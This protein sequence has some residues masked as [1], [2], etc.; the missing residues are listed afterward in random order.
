MTTLSTA[1]IPLERNLNLT[2]PFLNK[3]AESFE[4]I[5][6]IDWTWQVQGKENYETK[7]FYN[8]ISKNNYDVSYKP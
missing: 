8:A 2:P 5:F 6:G 7:L 4:V 1:T 3:A